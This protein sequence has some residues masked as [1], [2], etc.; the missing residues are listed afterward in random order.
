MKSDHFTQAVLGLDAAPAGH[1]ARM[2]GVVV[3]HLRMSAM[4]VGAV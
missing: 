2:L 3:L 1:R 4:D